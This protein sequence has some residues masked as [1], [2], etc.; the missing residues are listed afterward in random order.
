MEFINRKYWWVTLRDD[1]SEFIR[2]CDACARRNTGS[3]IKAPMG[4]AVEAQEFLD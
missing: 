3:K 4:E 2:K 1:V